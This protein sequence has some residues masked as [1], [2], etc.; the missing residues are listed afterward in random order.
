MDNL[1]NYYY[2]VTPFESDDAPELDDDIAS[3]LIYNE[4]YGRNFTKGFAL[5]DDEDQFILS[6]IGAE[7]DARLLNNFATPN[8]AS[9]SSRISSL[10]S[11]AD[12][13][14]IVKTLPTE[15]HQPVPQ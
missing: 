1:Y 11:P 5:P 14:P 2:A 8:I 10:I 7:E 4:L 6:D 13:D 15:P 3:D 9:P 12:I